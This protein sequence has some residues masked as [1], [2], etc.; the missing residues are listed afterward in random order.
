MT[1]LYQSL[2]SFW[3]PLLIG[4]PLLIHL[5]NLLRHR[6]VRWA[7]M[8]F[9]QISMRKN[10]NWVRFKQILLLLLRTAVIALVILMLAGPKA[11]SEWNSMFSGEPIHHFILVDDSLSMADRSGATKERADAIE[12]ARQVVQRIIRQAARQR[13]PQEVTVLTFSQAQRG[14]ATDVFRAPLNEN[15]VA[16][17]AANA[18][19]F[20]GTEFEA[21][22]EAALRAASEQTDF[23][24]DEKLALYVVSDFRAKDWSDA[25]GLREIVERIGLS[26]ADVHFVQCALPM[27]PNLAVVE[28][29]PEPDVRRLGSSVELRT[30]RLRVAVSNLSD[31]VAE[32]VKVTIE[33]LASRKSEKMENSEAPSGKYR[34][35]FDRIEAGQTVRQT[36]PEIPFYGPGNYPVVATLPDDALLADNRRYGVLRI[37]ERS[38]VLV[39]DGEENSIEGTIVQLVLSPGKDIRTGFECQ[40][41]SPE[42]LSHE[43][44]D[45]F[46]AV[47]LLNLKQLPRSAVD[48]LDRYVSQGG[49]VVFFASEANDLTFINDAL[50][51]PDQR[52]AGRGFFP[53]PLREARD[54]RAADKAKLKTDDAKR[55][56]EPDVL[57]DPDHPIFSRFMSR[58]NNW[59]VR[60][61]VKRYLAAE[62]EWEL[63]DD[64]KTAVL[65]RLKNGAPLVVE[66]RHGKGRC[67]AVLTSVD[68]K[69]NDWIGHREF[70]PRFM[71]E[72]QSYLAAGYQPNVLGIVGGPL[73][74]EFAAAEYKPEIEFILSGDDKKRSIRRRAIPVPK[75]AGR[76][77]A[78]V[79]EIASSGVYMV[80]LDDLTN[81]KGAVNI[82]YAYNVSTGEGKLQRVSQTE[83]KSNL[84]ESDFRFHLAHDFVA[85]IAKDAPNM[86]E[87]WAIF[88]VLMG[89]LAGEQLLAYSASY[90]PPLRAGGK[91]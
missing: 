42:F 40:L 17:V 73:R 14:V 1:F 16:D 33:V 71:N 64:G 6:R 34:V 28:L 87:H 74:V 41:E 44:L 56:I 80:R 81:G 78:T 86:G 85:N 79:E 47:Y 50:Y 11:P 9:L 68:G 7:A 38:P 83:M 60:L 25:T 37:S 3:L 69:W 22:P 48:A 58:R 35:T 65:A 82:D 54:L 36:S 5:I 30:R 18:S 62:K 52:G 19:S 12:S 77:Q 23:R 20:V 31:R 46:S 76:L 90:H 29:E 84:G 26:N 21:G 89:M 15:T 63:P 70:Y 39:V 10:R 57:A 55:D 4:I 91:K 32:N 13:V 45:E 53:L 59:L 66:R 72:M 8:N 24:S 75:K 49:N 2:I 67:I 43:S 27:Q 61:R 51:Q 88:L